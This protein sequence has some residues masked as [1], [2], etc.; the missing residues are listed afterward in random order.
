[1]S[2]P[3]LRTGRRKISPPFGGFTSTAGRGDFLRAYSSFSG[4]VLDGGVCADDR[5]RKKSHR[6]P[7]TVPLVLFKILDIFQP[8]PMGKFL[9]GLP[10]ALFALCPNRNGRRVWHIHGL[11]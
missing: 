3:M 10:L 11:L 2:T 1:M 7:E 4:A 8:L 5:Q 6:H 9:E